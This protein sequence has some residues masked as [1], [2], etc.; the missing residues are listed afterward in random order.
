MGFLSRFLVRCTV[1]RSSLGAAVVVASVVAVVASASGAV[2]G[3]EADVP[4]GQIIFTRSVKEGSRPSLYVMGANGSRVRLFVRNAA[5]AAVSPDGRW[6]AF[7]RGDAI[8]TMRRDGDK[9]RQ[10]T[11][12]PLRSKDPAATWASDSSPAW[13][14]DGRAVYFARSAFRNVSGGF[15]FGGMSIFSVRANGGGLRRLTKADPTDDGHCHD[16][17]APSPDGR[18]VAYANTGRCSH[19]DSGDILAINLK[20]EQVPIL[21]H[22]PAVTVFGAHAWW[23]VVG[24]D[25][26][27]SPDGR[28][29]AFA[30]MDL[31]ENGPKAYARSGIWAARVDGSQARRVYDASGS[32]QGMDWPSG[33]PSAPAWSSDGRWLAFVSDVVLPS[34]YPGEIFVVRSDGGGLRALTKTKTIDESDPAWLPLVS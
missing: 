26:A 6:L 11:K 7:V 33:W 8:W 2:A 29:L 27:W 30:V 25:P 13:S 21:G 1:G 31:S 23:S 17:P 4:T 28:R 14:A 20:G 34:S 22:F 12:P 19:G 5:D 3:P 9:Q 10:V 18:V 24:F 32:I 16:N 15:S